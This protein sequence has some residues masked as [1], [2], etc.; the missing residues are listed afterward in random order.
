MI[1]KEATV[2][3]A[4]SERDR[5]LKKGREG[6]GAE[7]GEELAEFKEALESGDK[8][9]ASEEL[10]DLLFTVVNL[11]RWHGLDSMMALQSTNRRFI[12][13]IAMLEKFADR[14]LSQYNLTELES[15][16]QKAKQELKKTAT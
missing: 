4:F 5:R 11:G 8:Q 15:L 1:D 12:Q 14:P 2:R 7:R 16:W 6:K 9:H 13:R 3:R 10:G